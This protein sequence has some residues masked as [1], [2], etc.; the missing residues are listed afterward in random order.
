[1]RVS[2]IWRMKKAATRVVSRPSFLSPNGLPGE[3]CE[4]A[5]FARGETEF[6]RIINHGTVPTASLFA[7][8]IEQR[9]IAYSGGFVV[10]IS[11]VKCTQ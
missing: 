4:H 10:P 2:R 5:D 8:A 3:G 11:Y 1:M 9:A 7:Q 6:I